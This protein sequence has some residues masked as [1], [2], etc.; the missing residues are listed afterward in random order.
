ML[1][2]SALFVI[3]YL[4]MTILLHWGLAP[5]R[6]VSSLLR[7]LAPSKKDTTPAAAAAGA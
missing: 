6:Q 1:I 3:A 7:E 5:L 4:G 2:I